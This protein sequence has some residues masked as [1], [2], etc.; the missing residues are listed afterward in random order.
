MINISGHNISAVLFD[1]DNTLVDRDQAV[2]R[3]GG[4][5]FRGVEYDESG[6]Y[7]PEWVQEF[8]RIDAG[9][10]IADKR[11]QMAMVI[12][13]LSIIGEEPDRFVKWWDR[14]YPEA[15]TL[16]ESTKHL[17][18]TLADTDTPWGIVTN[19]SLLQSFVIRAVGLDRLTKS[20]F[21]SSIIRLRKPD[22]AI[23][24]LAASSVSPGTELN[25]IL[26]VGDNPIADIEGAA[27]AG[28]KTV[29][30]SRGVDW[31]GKEQNP[32]DTIENIWELSNLI[33]SD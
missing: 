1:L 24:E 28:M 10:S 13:E 14:A 11:E 3:L 23:F 8:I 25:N 21:V 12:D 27:A 33:E 32:G 2:E 20:I 30:V 29:W 18:Q 26:F 9:G 19:G 4:Q 7:E 5:L 6:L 16:E 22:K 15:F 31:W 17:L